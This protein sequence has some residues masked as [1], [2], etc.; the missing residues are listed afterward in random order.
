MRQSLDLGGAAISDIVVAS[1][2]IYTL[3]S[4][5]RLVVL[6]ISGDLVEQRGSIVLADGGERF[7]AGNGVAYVSSRVAGGAGL[8]GYLT[9]DV[10]NP[11]APA[12]LSGIDDNSLAGSALALNGSGLGVVVGG[13]GFVFGGFKG[14]DVVSVADP[15]NTGAFNI[16][17]ALPDFGRDVTIANGVAFIADGNVGLQIV[18]Y[19][20][21][22]TLGIAPTASI[23]VAALD[24]DPG[25][26]GVQVL[27]GRSVHVIPTVGDDAQ[28]RNV[29]L[30]VNGTVVANDPTFPFD[31][32]AS[33][34]PVGT[35]GGTMTI[36]LRVTDTG[37]NATLSEM[38]TLNV[39]P[40]TFPPDVV[41]INVAEGAKQFGIIDKILDKRPIASDSK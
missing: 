15:A 6:T 38:V 7:T 13:I 35:E 31:L 10:S 37:G 4:A 28:V 36:Q 34:P 25:T 18:N 30:L 27:A 2:G 8:G 29:E 11:D 22:D 14:L 20:Q 5:H 12:L 32:F 39:V 33:A 1:D 3:D 17:Y 23:S 16:R 41:S 24:E 40:D 26:P 9:V 19:R 21:F